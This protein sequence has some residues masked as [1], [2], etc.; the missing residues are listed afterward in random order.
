VNIDA[1]PEAVPAAMPAS[2]S[3][4]PSGEVSVVRATGVIALGNI[5]SRVLGLARETLLSDLFGAGAAVDAFQVAVIVP[6]TLYDLLI[7]GHVNSALVP[8]LSEYAVRE[9]RAALW[10]LVSLLLGVATAILA[11]LVLALEMLAP[12]VIAL[13]SGGASAEAQVLAADLLR[14]TAPALFFLGLFAVLSGLLYALRRFTLPAFAGAVFNGCIVLVAL[15]VA[16]TLGITAMALGW[17]VG[18]VIQMGMQFVGL[19]GARLWPSLR[20]AWSNPG[21]RRIGL[22]YLP[23][24]FS[25]VIDTL[26]IR[27][28]SYHLA[29]QAGEASISYMNYATTLIQ[30]PHGLVATAISLAILPTL[31]RQAALI[32]AEGDKSYKDTLGRGLRL[33]VVLI[34]PATVGLFVLAAPVVRLIFEHGSFTPVDTAITSLALQLYLFGLPFAAVDLLL[35]FAFYARQ[36]TVTPALVGVISLGAYM[37]VALGLMPRYGLFSLMI[38]DSV[39]HMLHA[40]ISGWLLGRRTGGLHR[41]RLTPTALKAGVAA[42]AMGLMAY[43]CEQVITALIPPTLLVGELILVG[44]AGMIG[45]VTFL[46]LAA[47]FRVEELSWLW[48]MVRARLGRS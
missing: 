7:G 8:V 46:A 3:E 28:V 33:A 4:A 15:L 19:R 43:V 27:V 48:G 37:A 14:I 24:L 26:V 1:A 17:L 22:L 41:Q 11:L 38:A 6:R 29:S 21:L 42:L 36:D 31:S 2:E 10:R 25:L 39:K 40:G 32:A 16:P 9:G 5:A 45:A 35:V 18:A 34:L 20:G 13:V 47:L 12:Q 44:G 23:V 30:F